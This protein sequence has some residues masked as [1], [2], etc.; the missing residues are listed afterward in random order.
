MRRIVPVLCSAFLVAPPLAAQRDLTPL[1]VV[2]MKS[3]TG[4]I[5]SPDGSRIAFTRSEPRGPTAA[6]GAAYT[7]LSLLDGGGERGLVTGAVNIGTVAWQPDGAAVTF[8][9]RRDGD[10]GRQLYAMPMQGGEPRRVFATDLSI[11]TF[12]WRPDGGAVAFTAAAPAPAARAAARARGFTQT[13]VDEDWNPTNLY[14]WTPADGVRRLDVPGSVFDL[15]WS[16]DGTRL[17]LA[18]AP[19]PLVDDSYMFKRIHVLD[20]AT[21][22]V[23]RLV[24]NPGKLGQMAWSPDGT[25]LAYV[26]AADARDPHAG[27]LYLADARTGAVTPLTEGFEGMV[28]D[29]LWLDDGRVRAVVSRGIE[30]RVADLDVRARRWTDLT[31]NTLRV[32]D[33]E[34]VGRAV[35]AVMSGPAHPSEVYTLDGGTWTRRTNSNPW[36]GDVSLTRQAIHRFPASDSVTIEGILL[37]P[38]DFRAGTRYPLVIVAHGG[39][40]SHYGNQ[41]VTTYSEWGQLLSRDGYFVWYPNY[42]SSTGRGVAFAKADHGDPM[43]REFQ[44]HLDA[45]DDL[46]GRGW[47]DRARVGIGGGSYGGYTAAWAAT[48]HTDHFAAA[49]AFVPITWVPGLVLASDIPREF[50]YVHYEEQ[51]PHQAWDVMEARSPLTYAPHARTP[52][53]IAGG[54]SDPRVH[55]SQPFMLYRAVETM[56]DTP[57]RYVQY[58]GEPHGNRINV[59]RYDYT[60]RTLRW[61]RQYL[62]PGDHRADPPPPLDVDYGAWLGAGT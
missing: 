33:I 60:L 5:P 54:T 29:L 8:L 46:V 21:G 23:R 58:P 59:F 22:A 13:V 27:M 51:W 42:R 57:V 26:S 61:F 32:E 12:R 45:I 11:G 14:L 53:F 37:Y 55:P 56:T 31:I 18:L 3:V 7:T 35:A 24:D 17:A 48:R 4:A 16:P 62:A 41:W 47:V 20:L 15:A 19:R 2:T 38:R 1:D 36:L 43:G 25:R 6:P 40:E 44:D 10:A 9:E 28:H 34:M 50:Y 30:S 52:L 49:V 39:P